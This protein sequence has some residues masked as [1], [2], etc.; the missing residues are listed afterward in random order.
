MLVNPITGAVMRLLSQASD[1]SVILHP[2]C[3]AMQATLLMISRS[4]GV[5]PYENLGAFAS[6]AVR[7]VVPY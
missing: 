2:R 1:T 6:T 3:S 5:C 4:C 7:V